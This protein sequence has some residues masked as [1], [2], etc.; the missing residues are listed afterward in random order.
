MHVLILGA[1]AP[2]CLAWARAFAQAGWTVSVGDSLNLPLSRFSR[3]A[4]HFVRLPPP[5]RDPQ[6]WIEA[7]VTAIQARSIDLVLPT[8]EEVFYLTHGREALIPFC[9]VLTS[10]FELVHRLHHKGRFAAITRNWVLTVP[11]THLLVDRQALLRFGD[12]AARWVFKPAYSRFASQTLIRPSIQQ[13]VE[14]EPSHAQP[15][16]AQRFVQGRELCSFSILIN[17]QLRAHGCYRPRYRAGRGAGIYFQPEAPKHVRQF[18][19]QFGRETC[20]TGQVGFDFIQDHAGRIHVL[21]CNPRATSGVH[22]F[23]NQCEKLVNSLSDSHMPVL[24][25]TAEPRMAALAM[26]LLAAPQHALNAGFWRDY[27]RAYD[28]IAKRGDFWPLAAQVLTLG[29]IGIRA[30]YRRCGFL[31]ASTADIEWNGQDLGEQG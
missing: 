19:E 23:D 9:R 3:A 31:A 24:E 29:E 20:Y 22:L 27:L 2:A 7:L 28:V 4:Q 13:L 16:V 10:D 21:E 14:I 1:R 12:D 17:G 26:I 30:I 11:E 6:A 15:W 8:C 25:P 5:R 18:L